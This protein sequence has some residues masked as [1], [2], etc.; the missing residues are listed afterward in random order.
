LGAH[1]LSATATDKAGNTGTG[2]AGRFGDAG[3]PVQAHDAVHRGLG[4]LKAAVGEP[5]GQRQ[6]AGE[7]RMPRGCDPHGAN[8]AA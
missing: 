6:Q 7:C 2:S 5:A 4:Q 8:D 1:S 3:E